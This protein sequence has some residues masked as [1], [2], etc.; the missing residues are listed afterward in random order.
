MPTQKIVFYSLMDNI[1]SNVLINPINSCYNPFNTLVDPVL[2]YCTRRHVKIIHRLIIQS[3]AFCN[4]AYRLNTLH[5]LKFALSLT[6]DMCEV[7]SAVTNVISIA[8]GPFQLKWHSYS[9]T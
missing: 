8:D 5:H 4:P 9:D 6:H 2:T 3:N 7:K 1:C